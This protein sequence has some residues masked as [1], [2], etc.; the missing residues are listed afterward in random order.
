MKSDV[1]IASD[2]RLTRGRVEPNDEGSP[3]PLF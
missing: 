1:D 3:A 2:G